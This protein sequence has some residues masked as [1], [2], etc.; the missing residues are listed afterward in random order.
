MLKRVVRISNQVI[1]KF[2]LDVVKLMSEDGVV[3]YDFGFDK[4]GYESFYF[5]NDSKMMDFLFSLPIDRNVPS[6]RNE[7]EFIIGLAS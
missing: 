3:I 5:D 1:K 6:E 7:K 4:K 2:N